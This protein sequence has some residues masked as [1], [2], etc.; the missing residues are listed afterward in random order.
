MGAKEK[1]ITEGQLADNVALLITTHE[2][3][4]RA[5]SLYQSVARSFVK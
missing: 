4:E 5:V 3:A 1:Y 2:A